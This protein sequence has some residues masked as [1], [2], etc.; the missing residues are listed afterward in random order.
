MCELSC[1]TLSS[2]N[3]AQDMWSLGVILYV[4]LSGT[5][6]F[7]E[8]RNTPVFD[9]IKSGDYSFPGEAWDGVSAEG[10]WQYHHIRAWVL[11]PIQPST[12]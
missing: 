10:T 11:T 6:P 7:Y 2:L 12:S 8:G 4:I 9:Q 5:A 1:C 3:L